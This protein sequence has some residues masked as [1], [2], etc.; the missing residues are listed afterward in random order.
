[1]SRYRYSI[2]LFVR[3]CTASSSALDFIPFAVF[4][5]G[6]NKYA[7]LAG[8]CVG[9]QGGRNSAKNGGNYLIEFQIE[10]QINTR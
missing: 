5:L 10:K 6:L 1:M 7:Y 8:E 4:V 9:E 3:L 2:D